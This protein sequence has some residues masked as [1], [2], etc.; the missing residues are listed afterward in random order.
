MYCVKGTE[1]ILTRGDTFRATLTIQDCNGDIYVPQPGDV[2][3]FAMKKRY[4]DKDV[5][6]TKIID[7]ETL[8]LKLSP[9][10]TKSLLFGT[11]VYDIELTYSSGD[12]DTFIAGATLRLM[13]EVDDSATNW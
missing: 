5:L 3:R 11:Y 9:E 10:D 7:N 6:L 1:I 2:I 13:E 8:T 12:V 4:S